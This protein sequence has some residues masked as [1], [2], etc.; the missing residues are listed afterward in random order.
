MLPMNIQIVDRKW[1][2]S[3]EMRKK[4]GSSFSSSHMSDNFVD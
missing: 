4:K 1:H 2:L 3:R